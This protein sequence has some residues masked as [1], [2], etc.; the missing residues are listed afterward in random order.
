[1]TS[2][3]ICLQCAYALEYSEPGA[4]QLPDGQRYVVSTTDEH[5]SMFHCEGCDA[6]VFSA[7]YVATADE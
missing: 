6:Q 1:M 2:Y 7:Q 4:E 5:Q 3:E